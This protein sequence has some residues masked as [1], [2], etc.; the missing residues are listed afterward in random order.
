M[1]PTICPRC[2]SRKAKDERFCNACLPWVVDVDER[3]AMRMEAGEEE[4][5]AEDKALKELK[6]WWRDI[7]S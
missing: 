2:F 3:K 5:A 6:I 1:N 4:E 7:S